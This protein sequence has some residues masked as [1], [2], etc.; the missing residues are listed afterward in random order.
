VERDFLV[1]ERDL[2]VQ[3]TI[4]VYNSCMQASLSST[5]FSVFALLL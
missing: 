5:T 3:N 2:I 1:A 4:I